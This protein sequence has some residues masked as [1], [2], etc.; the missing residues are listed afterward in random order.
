MNNDRPLP[1]V[2][3]F[4]AFYAA[5]Y[6]SAVA[7]AYVLVGSG[8]AAEDLAQE[9]FL[10]AYRQWDRIRDYD[11]PR[12]WVRRVLVNRATSALRRRGA[13]FRALTRLGGKGDSAVGDIEAA[14]EAVWEEVR[15]L[16]RRQAQAVA[17]HYVDQLSVDEVA[18]VLGCSAGTVK[19]HLSRARERL[20]RTLQDHEVTS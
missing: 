12:A 3:S 6:R 17:L 8:A 7:L 15:R 11:D 16:P 1:R 4:D 10:T 18:A 14:D 2:E 13:E 20:G 19:T 9:A 5:G